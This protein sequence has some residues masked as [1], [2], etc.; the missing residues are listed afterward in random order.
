MSQNDGASAAS[1]SLGRRRFYLAAALAVVIVAAMLGLLG[2]IYRLEI[3]AF[4]ASGYAFITDRDRIKVFIISFGPNAP[5]V[6]MALQILQVLLAPVPGE[7]TGFL[8]GYLFGA[9]KGFVYSSIGL[10][11]GSYLN[12]LAGRFLGK[13]YI[14][15]LIPVGPLH[16]FESLLQR[17]G[18]FVVFIL[19]LFPGFPKDYL[20]LFLGLTR[21]P[22]KAFLILAAVGRMPGTLLLSLQ[23]AYV[24]A[25]MYLWFGVLLGLCLVLVLISY[26]FRQPLYQWIEKMNHS[27]G[28]NAVDD[29]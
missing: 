12:F 10:T 8:G 15:K 22:L 23:G 4:C 19:F 24:F 18:L 27:T 21:L 26:C 13:K 28:D 29:P 5:V 3:G 16:K 25:R 1:G 7:A 11:M 20:C 9:T 14:R 6:F 2:Y 17:Q